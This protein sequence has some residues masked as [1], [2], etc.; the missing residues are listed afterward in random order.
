MGIAIA[1][2]VDEARNRLASAIDEERQHGRS[3]QSD[4][5]IENL[6]KALSV[7]AGELRDPWIRMSERLPEESVEVLV[8]LDQEGEPA[9]VTIAALMDLTDSGSWLGH[10][11]F[12][13]DDVSH[14]MPLPEPPE[15]K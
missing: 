5:K 13:D 10:G 3:P 2:M 11:V 8:A 15:V 12:D 7:I 6:L 14:W 4:E 1:D 9:R